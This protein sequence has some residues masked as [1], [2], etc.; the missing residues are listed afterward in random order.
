MKTETDTRAAS[1]FAALGPIVTVPHAI[2]AQSG[3]VLA[4]VHRD[5]EAQLRMTGAA[6]A[7]KN[8]TERDAFF[9]RYFG[10][11]ALSVMEIENRRC[12]VDH[13]NSSIG[14]VLADAE[15]TKARQERAEAEGRL[16]ADHMKADG[17]EILALA[18]AGLSAEEKA[19][20][21]RAV[22][23]SAGPTGKARLA[24]LQF[25]ETV[26]AGEMRDLGFE[27]T[28]GETAEKLVRL[29]HDRGDA[30]RTIAEIDAGRHPGTARRIE[31]MR[32]AAAKKLDEI[33]A[34]LAPLKIQP[35]SV[36]M[37]A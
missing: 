25:L 24:R 7:A 19:I 31:A 1:P 15:I 2:L 14:R 26:I 29:L 27:M 5:C 8:S 6:L 35:P 36:R 10:R 32:K 12:L 3:A 37:A 30:V 9:D 11:P 4:A 22:R 28:I 20:S 21:A 34:E 16:K 18:Y 23:S 33:D 17:V 13:M